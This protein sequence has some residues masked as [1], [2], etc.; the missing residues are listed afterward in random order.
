[1]S[2][3]ACTL[4]QCYGSLFWQIAPSSCSACPVPRKAFSSNVLVFL[5]LLSISPLHTSACLP[6]T[7][8]ALFPSVPCPL[9]S[10]EGH[11]CHGVFVWRGKAWRTP[12]P[13]LR[14]GEQSGL[15]A[16]GDDRQDPVWSTSVEGQEGAGVLLQDPGLESEPRAEKRSRRGC[17]DPYG[18]TPAHHQPQLVFPGRLFSSHSWGIS[19]PASALL[20]HL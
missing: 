8:L 3:L 11:C 5:P 9:P 10:A 6:A 13:P 20:F 4:S 2:W 16:T 19:Q 14:G 17:Q 15:S 12:R 1:M 7:S 18:A